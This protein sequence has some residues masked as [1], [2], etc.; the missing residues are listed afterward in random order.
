MIIVNGEYIA[1]AKTLEI[2]I[3]IIII[4]IIYDQYN[5]DNRGGGIRGG[6]DTNYKR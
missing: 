5:V 1:I 2:I 4:I 3:I 6:L